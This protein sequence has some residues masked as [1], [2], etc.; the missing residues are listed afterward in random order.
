MEFSPGPA[1]DPNIFHPR[2]ELETFPEGW[3]AELLT[4]PEGWRCTCGIF[5]KS[6]PLSRHFPPRLELLTFPDGWRAE[7]LIFPECRLRIRARFSPS[8]GAKHFPPRLEL[9]AFPEDWRPARV[10]F[11]P[12]RGTNPDIFRPLLESL[13]F[14]RERWP[15]FGIFTKPWRQ[16]GHFLHIALDRGLFRGPPR[17]VFSQTASGILA[18]L[19]NWHSRPAGKTTP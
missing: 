13:A 5:T 3:R 16:A 9:L 1:T 17:V 11:S 12:S 4:F 14:P 7:L 6:R 19:R 18:P 8:P 2:L 10:R 15:P